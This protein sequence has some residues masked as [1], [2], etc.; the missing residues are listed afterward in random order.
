MRYNGHGEKL[1]TKQEL[2]IAALLNATSIEEA[3]PVAK[4]HVSTIHRWMRQPEFVAA[5]R[6][7][8]RGI[9]RHAI[10]RLQRACRV[11]TETLLAVMQDHEAPSIV[12]VS[13]A[14]TILEM[15]VRVVELED[16]GARL[17]HLEA[18]LANV[19]N[20][21]RLRGR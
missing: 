19:K 20:G 16:V 3:A 4:V 1:S 14:R 12:R 7:A 21:T 10:T 15:A 2:V 11:A 17:A 18:T 5:Y 13:A 9:M 6:E 8:S